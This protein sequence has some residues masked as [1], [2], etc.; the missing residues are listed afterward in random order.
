LPRLLLG[1]RRILL[2]ELLHRL[3]S[4]RR[5]QHGDITARTRVCA[6]VFAYT[7]TLMQTTYADNIWYA[8]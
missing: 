1:C 2:E 4:G 7:I 6:R 5:R 3:G 8:L